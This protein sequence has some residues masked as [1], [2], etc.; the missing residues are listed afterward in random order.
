MQMAFPIVQIRT[1]A[2][3]GHFRTNFELPLS[4]QE[5]LLLPAR[6]RLRTAGAFGV[7]VREPGAEQM[8]RAGT[9]LV[10]VPYA[11]YDGNLPAGTQVIIQRMR[12]DKMEVTVRE[13]EMIGQERWMAMRSRHPRYREGIR[14][15]WPQTGRAWQEEDGDRYLLVGVVASFYTPMELM[16]PNAKN[17]PET[18]VSGG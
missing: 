11:Q 8:H 13:I 4:E 10:V 12:E 3:A 18:N 17:P 7:T 5:E 2:R 14:L 16:S 6:E 15:P 9:I 1:E